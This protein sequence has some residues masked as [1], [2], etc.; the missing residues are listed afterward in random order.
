MSGEVTIRFAGPEDAGLLLRLIRELAVF[1]RAPEAV[2]ATEADLCARVLDPTRNSR[3]CSLFS[4]SEP[5]G[6]AV[7]HS[8]F[9]TWLGRAGALSR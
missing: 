1:E 3:R 8:R 9:S 4:T 6:I 5:A 7:F 2:V